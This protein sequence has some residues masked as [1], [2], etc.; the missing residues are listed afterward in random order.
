ME[1]NKLRN[2]IFKNCSK[3]YYLGKNSE[4]KE[5]INKYTKRGYFKKCLE[6]LN[7]YKIVSKYSDTF[8]YNEARYLKKKAEQ[9]INSSAMDTKTRD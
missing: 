3:L 9:I 2:K 8:Y 7:Y 4:N 1:H 5:T 6:L